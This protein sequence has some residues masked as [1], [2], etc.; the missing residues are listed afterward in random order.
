MMDVTATLRFA[1][2]A[3]RKARLVARTLRGL[4]VAA[5]QAHLRVLPQRS[6]PMLLKLLNS[7]VANA[8]NNFGLPGE[9]LVV[10]R[11]LVNEGPK[12]KRYRP[13]SRGM[14]NRLLKRTS[15]IE[16]VLTEQSPSA[17]VRPRAH[18]LGEATGGLRAGKKTDIVTK[19]VGELKPEEL[20]AAEGPGTEKKAAGA[21]KGAVRPA[22]APRGVRRLIERKHG[23]E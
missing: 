19:K 3:P 20:R 10:R 23:G 16:V 12:L 18:G 2:I 21:Q 22:E 7:A 1:R 13:R 17:A 6:A 14:A 8:K 4:P 9:T 15:H 11:V 5:A